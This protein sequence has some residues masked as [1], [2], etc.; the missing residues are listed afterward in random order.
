MII[1]LQLEQ[2]AIGYFQEGSEGLIGG[3]LPPFEI[4]FIEL[5]LCQ[6]G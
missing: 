6:M 2:G 1:L 4:P 5:L 3:L